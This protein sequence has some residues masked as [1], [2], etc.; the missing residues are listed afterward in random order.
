M[1]DGNPEQ[2]PVT[3]QPER[4]APTFIALDSRMLRRSLILIIG[5]VL[6]LALIKWA[7]EMLAGFLFLI[8]LS[9]LIAISFDPVVSFLAR[10]RMSRGLAT[11]IV[12]IVVLGS[13]GAFIALLGGALDTQVVEL[14]LALPELI[15]QIVNWINNISNSRS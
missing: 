5:A 9:W 1:S 13:I 4:Q 8:L 10:H 12:A 6:L 7:W 11:A 14:I 15:L 3:R 2:A